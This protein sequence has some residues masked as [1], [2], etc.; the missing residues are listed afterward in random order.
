MIFKFS[1]V[2]VLLSLLFVYFNVKP[3][4]LN[5]KTLLDQDAKRVKF[6]NSYI[7]LESTDAY[8]NK[9]DSEHLVHL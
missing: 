1:L 7:L 6:L 4:G 5:K 8:A 3:A 9:C 2:C